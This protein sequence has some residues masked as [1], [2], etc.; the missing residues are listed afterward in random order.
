[1]RTYYAEGSKTL[2]FEIAEQLGWQAP[3][4]VVVP[5]GSGSQLTK[6]AKGFSELGKVGLLPE[7]PSVRISGAQAEGCS[8]VAAAFLEGADAIRPVK[9]K[10]IA[11]SLAIGNPADGWYALDVVRRSGGS[12]ATVTDTEIVDAIGLLARTEGIFAETAGGVTIAT[13]C[14]LA[15]SGAIRPDER[16]VALVTGHGLK[17]VE[18]LAGAPGSTPTATIA[19]TLDA[20]D[21]A[22][23][24]HETGN[25]K[26]RE[27]AR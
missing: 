17:T 3:D 24:D 11:K 8:P 20:F 25:Q 13:L 5:I 10:T 6:V 23:D 4:H 27:N 21:A 15:A 9:P 16:V 22:V 7:E 12:C 1:V 19:P 26:N 14:K 2:A 18:A